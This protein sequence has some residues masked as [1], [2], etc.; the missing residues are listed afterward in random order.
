MITKNKFGIS[1][2]TSFPES[3]EV[4]IAEMAKAGFESSFFK[5][6]ENTDSYAMMRIY[7]KNNL[8]VDSIH[9]PFDNLNCIWREGTQG[10]DYIV[11]LSRCIDDAAAL[12]IPHIVI[13]PICGESVPKSSLIGIER[14]RKLIDYSL[15]AGV[16]VCF[17]NVEFSEMLGV[18]MSEFGN[19]VGFC[20]D[21]GH[22]STND[23]GIRFLALY[24]DRLAC[25]HI[26][27]NYGI[28]YMVT[29]IMHG[30]CHMI[31]LDAA[32]D[33]KRV[34]R[35]IRSVNYKGVLMLETNRHGLLGTYNDY[36]VREFYERAYAAISE[37]SSYEFNQTVSGKHC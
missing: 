23:P 9:A 19:D 3:D 35:D 10:D 30:D 12:H 34:M 7:E 4:K 6:N 2:P 25:T 24:G 20:Y 16:K 33:F 21:T 32:I 11:R 1:L 31:P 29:P 15:E 17:E 27:D 14:F 37:I 26:H 18:V 13:H 36:T 22:E 28:S 8:E 5:W